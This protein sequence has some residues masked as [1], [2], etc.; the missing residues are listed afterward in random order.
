MTAVFPRSLLQMNPYIRHNFSTQVFRKRAIQ[1]SPFHLQ[2]TARCP[3][4]YK[5][6]TSIGIFHELQHSLA[7]LQHRYY[8]VTILMV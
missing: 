6:V 7:R 5:L 4:F 8:D 1:L 2:S 3:P